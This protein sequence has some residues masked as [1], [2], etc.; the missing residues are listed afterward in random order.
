[1]A[2][3]RHLLRPRDEG[4]CTLGAFILKHTG[5]LSLALQG[6]SMSAAQGQQVAEEVCKTVSR[7]RS[8]AAFDLFWTW[9][10]KRKSE[11]DAVAEPQ[12]PRKR[13]TPAR[14]EAGDSGT[15][16]FSSTPKEYFHHMYY[17][18]IDVTT[19]CIRPRFNQKDFRVYQSIQ[20]LLLKAVAGED[21]DE[22]LATVMAVYGDTDLQQSKLEAQLSLLPE[23]VRA[24]GYDTSRF[25]IAD[26]LDFFQSL[27]NARKL[28]LNEN[29]TL[30]KLMLVMPAFAVSERS[31]SA[32]KRVKTYLRSTTGEGRLNHLMLLHVHK[33]WQMVLTWWRS[34]ICLWGTTSG[35]SN[36]LGS[37]KKR[38]ADE[39]Y[40]CL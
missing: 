25:D 29:C 11:V 22:E 4:R 31:F 38:P 23:V 7:D 18:A 10:L 16:Y 2:T 27:G 5:N 32:L 26:L 24:M 1:M 34:P 6:S 19:E 8:E 17:A 9:L 3:F 33:N 28:L 35:A 21:H 39:V 14:Q 36:C 40:V 13:R 30:G 15:H 37:F 12:L 20:E